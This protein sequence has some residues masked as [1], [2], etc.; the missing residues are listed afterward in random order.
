[1]EKDDV[2]RLLKQ[3]NI[4]DPDPAA[5]DRA[6]QAA[7]DELLRISD[8]KEKKGKGIS[9]IGRLMGKKEERSDKAHEQGVEEANALIGMFDA[10]TKRKAAKN[11]ASTSKA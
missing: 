10:E 9:I 6:L 1:M 3:T 8:K 4:H 5:R 7:K 2:C 11:K